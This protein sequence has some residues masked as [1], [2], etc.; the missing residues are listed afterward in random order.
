VLDNVCHRYSEAQADTLTGLNL[1]VEAGEAHA[2]LGSSG[3]GKTTLLNVL[4]GLE[5]PAAGRV[6]FD[7]RDVSRI[8]PRGRNISQVFQFP[9]LY[10]SLTVAENLEFPLKTRRMSAAERRRRA[11][12]I[13][14]QLSVVDLLG[15]KPAT[16]SLF[17]KQ[18]VA[19]GRALVR[20]EVSVV[21]LDEPLTAVEPA[22]KWQLRRVL[23]SAQAELGAT[24][25]YVTHDQTEA[26]TFADRISVL[27][28]GEILQT[29]SAETLFDRPS[30]EH[31][32][33]FIGAPGMNLVAGEIADGAYRIAGQAVAAAAGLPAGPCTVGF[34]PEWAVAVRGQGSANGHGLPAKITAVR[35]LGAVRGQRVGVVTAEL[36]GAQI[37]LRQ[38]LDV[39]P[40]DEAAVQIRGERVLGFRNGWRLPG[41]LEAGGG[42]VSHPGP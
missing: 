26:L 14:E 12:A 3:A 23:K 20:P 39:E 21:L 2:L 42:E 9:V 4:S 30:H 28:G 7:G 24:M 36:A 1:E 35:T 27:H 13:A 33:H 25:I 5:A 22:T 34:R 32:A 10:E 15:A 17:Q 29:G 40:G 18:L 38:V 31:V 6:L 11:G 8:P 16:L 19:I 41:G 37:N